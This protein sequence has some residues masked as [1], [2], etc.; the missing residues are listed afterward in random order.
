MNESITYGEED[1]WTNDPMNKCDLCGKAFRFSCG[2][3]YRAKDLH[4]P[5]DD[6]PKFLCPTCAKKE[7]GKS[8]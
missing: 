6:Q 3:I 7:R 2:V 5:V 4:D 1:D 8:K